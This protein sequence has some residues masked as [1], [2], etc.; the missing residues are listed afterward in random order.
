MKTAIL[1]AMAC[2]AFQLGTS[3]DRGT[4]APPVASSDVM[5]ALGREFRAAD[6]ALE[7]G[8]LDGARRAVEGLLDVTRRLGSVQVPSPALIVSHQR[9]IDALGR[10]ILETL[11]PA[12][13]HLARSAF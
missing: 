2:A 12:T 6:T 7:Q 5:E 10:E 13:V 1:L 4:S 8:D 9:R 11:A 3:G